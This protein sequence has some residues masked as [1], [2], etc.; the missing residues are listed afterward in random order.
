MRGPIVDEYTQTAQEGMQILRQCSSDINEFIAF[1]HSI[2]ASAEQQENARKWASTAIK[3]ISSEMQG[4][5]VDILSVATLLR[6]LHGAGI[7]VLECSLSN[8]VNEE[9]AEAMA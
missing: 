2:R 5:H 7:H 9:F 1:A 4:E 3:T 8:M 6:A